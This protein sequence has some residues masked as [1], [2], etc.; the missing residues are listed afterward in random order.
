MSHELDF[1]TGQAAIAYRGNVPW[2][3]YGFEMPANAPIETWL[4]A[5]KLNWE[6][7]QR[8][9]WTQLNEDTPT[10]KIERMRAL[11]RS[12]TGDVLSVVGDKYKVVQP[13]EVLEFFRDLVKDQGFE[14]E[15]AGALAGGARVWALAKTG[16]SFKA[17]KDDAVAAYL[18][19]ATSYDKKFATT[20][21]FTGI[22]VV[23]NNTMTIALN[24]GE[25]QGDS[26]V[27]RVPHCTE[28]DAFS[29]KAQLG[30]LGGGW[31]QY[32]TDVQK[33]V[34]TPIS[35]DDAI[36]FFLELSG[37]DKAKTLEEQTT[38][39][40]FTRKLLTSYEHAP[41]QQLTSADGTLWGV[42]NAVTHFTDHVRRARDRGSRVNSSWFGPSAQMKRDAWDKAMELA[43]AA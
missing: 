16:E 12:D 20:A 7:R 1:T 43:E 33:L 31:Q 28:F 2:H 38:V 35:K 25:H 14:I 27:F 4:E 21:Q 22:R 41:G 40:Y 18:L 32:Q 29:A 5:A 23:C 17:G 36:K 8:P 6:V 11:V 39:N 37:F 15:T 42:V 24:Q 30:L 19:L 26:T 10:T 13:R 9:V 3:G 34:A